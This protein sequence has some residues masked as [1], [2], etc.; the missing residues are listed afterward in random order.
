[1]YICRFVKNYFNLNSLR[2]RAASNKLF[3]NI[4]TNEYTA[5]LILKSAN[6]LVLTYMNEYIHI[7][8]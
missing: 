7:H 6:T 4:T 3:V 1:M 5:V 8:I 2:V